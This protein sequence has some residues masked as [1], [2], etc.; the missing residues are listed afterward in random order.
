MIDLMGYQLVITWLLQHDPE[1]RPTA[2]ELSQSPLLPERLEDEYFKNALRLMGKIS[3]VSLN[4][5][6]EIAS[7]AKPDSTQHQAVLATL[8][9][10]PPRLARA[11]VYDQ[12]ADSP[13]YAALNQ[14]VRDQLA[15]IFHR[16]GAVDMEPPLLMPVIDPDEEKNQAIFI[17]RQGDIV[18]LPNNI[19]VPFAR[20]AG[21]QNIRRIKRY[22]ITNVYRPQ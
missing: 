8:F 16:H 18:S 4:K 9:K 3:A 12:E 14:T 5:I 6:S 1:K 21:R 15:V 20:L 13:D 7:Q 19:L 11:F 22:H 17:D 2:L 10:Q